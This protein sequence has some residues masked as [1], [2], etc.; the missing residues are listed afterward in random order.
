MFLNCVIQ[1]K[2]LCDDNKNE[3]LSLSAADVLSMLS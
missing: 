1:T 3:K 2:I